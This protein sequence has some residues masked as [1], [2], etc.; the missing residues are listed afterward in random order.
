MSEIESQSE[1]FT[2]RDVKDW[3][4]KVIAILQTIVSTIQDKTMRPLG[5]VLGY[6]TAGL[7]AAVLIPVALIL[8]TIGLVRVLNVYLFHQHVWAGEAIVGLLLVLI[9]LVLIKR[10]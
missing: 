6:A 7:A 5:K 4:A 1:K 2:D 9:G 8:G 10:H 3:P